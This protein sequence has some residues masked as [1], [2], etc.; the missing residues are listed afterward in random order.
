MISRLGYQFSRT[1][2]S[3]FLRRN[4]WSWRVPTRVQLNKFSL[5]N[6]KYY[7]HFIASIMDIPVD[8]I[9]YMDEAHVVERVI[10]KRKA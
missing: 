10:N 5:A 1:V 8:R 3:K 6:K 4:R 9:K 2:L 7:A